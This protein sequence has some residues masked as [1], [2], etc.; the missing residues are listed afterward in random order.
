VL[1]D[2]LSHPPGEDARGRDGVDIVLE[3]EV[4]RKARRRDELDELF[5][6]LL[7]PGN[8]LELFDG[9]HAKEVVDDAL[10]QRFDGM[11]DLTTCNSTVLADFLARRRRQRLRTVQFPAEQEPWWAAQCIDLALRLFVR[12]SLDYQEARALATAMMVRGVGEIPPSSPP[13]V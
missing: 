12:E 10:D 1:T 6:G 7:R 3:S 4:T 8:R 13:A 11:L 2:A 9:L 5:H